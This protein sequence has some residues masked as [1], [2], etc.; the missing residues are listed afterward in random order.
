MR[1]PRY[2]N[3]HNDTSVAVELALCEFDPTYVLPGETSNFEVSPDQ[4]MAGCIVN[5]LH[6]AGDYYLGCLVFPITG[7]DP[8]SEILVSAANKSISENECENVNG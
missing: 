1:P 2:V 3:V 5:P 7:L 8:N 6:G 4:P